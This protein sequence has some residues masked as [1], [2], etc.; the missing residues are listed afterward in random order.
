M[1]GKLDVSE[2][3]S[4]RTTFA[5]RLCHIYCTVENK[6]TGRKAFDFGNFQLADGSLSPYYFD[7]RT[8]YA[9]PKHLEEIAEML[10]KCIEY[11]VLGISRDKLKLDSAPIQRIAGIPNASLGLTAL[12]S[13]KLGMP[14]FYCHVKPFFKEL[15]Y[16]IQGSLES[17]DHV[18]V[19]D[20]L[21]TG[22][23]RKTEN[24]D[25]ITTNG[26]HVSQ[27]VVV[28]DRQE[29]AEEKLKERGIALLS[30]L[31][32]SEFAEIALKEGLIEEEQKNKVIGHIDQAR[33]KKGLPAISS[34]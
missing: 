14:S 19:I 6:A 22:A 32:A 29:G 33:A 7:F 9:Y 34:G 13:V 23:L 11:N 15:K 25:I 27:V 4:L 16:A 21:A 18:L 28:I 31:R 1:P 20:D 26:G 10:T 17:G 8:V 3:W 5:S 12:I 30:L 2:W 24:I